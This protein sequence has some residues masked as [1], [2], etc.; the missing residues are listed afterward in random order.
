VFGR[1]NKAITLGAATAI[2]A[3]SGAT[4]MAQAPAADEGAPLDA[5]A[6]TYRQVF[7]QMSDATARA[8]A[9]K[10]DER[11]ALTESLSSRNGDTFG[12]A[13]FDPP[14]GVL[15]VNVTSQL[16]QARAEQLAGDL[17]VQVQTHL[18]KHNLAKLEAKAEKLRQKGDAVGRAANGKVG[19]SVEENAVVAAVPEAQRKAL[20]PAD[21]PEGV[22]VV[23]DPGIRAQEDAGC[24]S[25]SA[26]DWTI[27]AG[28]II[29]TGTSASKVC[30]V[31]FTARNSLN[32]RYTYTA[33][34]CSGGNGITWGTGALAIGPM[35]AS[36]NSGVVDSSIIRVTNGWFTGDT[37]GEIYMDSAA[38]KTVNLN[39]AAP[40]V[41]YMLQGER[42][43]LSANYT[44]PNGAN[45]CGVIGAVSDAGVRGMT[46]VNGLDGCP[47]DSG[48]G[49]YWVTSTGRRIAYGIHSRSDTGCHGDQ[50]GTRSWY[51]PVAEA[52][53][54]FAPSLNIE[55]RP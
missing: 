16:T 53:N 14:S 51:T 44:A 30:S 47:G 10:E 28:S 15:H 40:T 41:S 8:A 21:V 34:H 54:R 45:L 23:K 35:Q 31:G 9:A 6:K 42:V 50:G 36:M 29:W 39:G 37:G 27:R 43:C 32:Q 12:G 3:L 13:Y 48:G 18:V 49:W 22:Q 2:L 7:P 20:K 1:S 17:G 55:V 11:K 33:G 46:R 26:C 19:I 25:R 4:A 38:G 24:T 5:A 52:K